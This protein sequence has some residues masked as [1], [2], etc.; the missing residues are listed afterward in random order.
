MFV[1]N[2]ISPFLPISMAMGKGGWWFV[3]IC[4]SK[5][6]LLTTCDFL[7]HNTDVVLSGL[8]SQRCVLSVGV[9]TYFLF[10]ITIFF[11]YYFLLLLFSISIFYFLLPLSHLKYLIKPLSFSCQ[12]FCPFAHFDIILT[13]KIESPL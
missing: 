9:P 7:V 8:H 11:Y 13:F 3:N 6:K 4:E 5:D 12:L 2:C 1:L 10:S